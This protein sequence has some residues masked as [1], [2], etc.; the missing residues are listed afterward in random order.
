MPF[1]IVSRSWPVEPTGEDQTP[2]E[3]KLV[4]T[5]ATIEEAEARVR[6]LIA[7]FEHTG[8]NSQHHHWWARNEGESARYTFTVERR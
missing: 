6:E 5:A 2:L 7:P 4:A 3:E 8:Y 1:V